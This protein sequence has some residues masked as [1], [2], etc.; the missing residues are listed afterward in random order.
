MQEYLATSLDLPIYNLFYCYGYNLFLDGFT[1]IALSNPHTCFTPPDFRLLLGAL[2]ATILPSTNTASSYGSG[3]AFT[4][5]PASDT[6][7]GAS[8]IYSAQVDPG[9]FSTF[10]QILSLVLNA[11]LHKLRILR[12]F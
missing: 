1:I 5:A 8:I 9:M 12:R 2:Q 10:P 7:F 4:A 3:T 11:M 6:Q